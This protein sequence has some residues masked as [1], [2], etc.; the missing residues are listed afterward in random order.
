M[1]NFRVCVLLSWALFGY[2][3][4]NVTAQHRAHG[5]SNPRIIFPWLLICSKPWIPASVFHFWVQSDAEADVTLHQTQIYWKFPLWCLKFIFL[6]QK[7]FSSSLPVLY[8]S[9]MLIV[10]GI[11]SLPVLKTSCQWLCFHWYWEDEAI[12]RPTWLPQ[13]LVFNPLLFLKKCYFAVLC[14]TQDL[15][16]LTKDW[17]HGPRIGSME[18]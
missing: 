15:S 17:T 13:L 4:H 9:H 3:N 1:W 5:P 7:N 10:S 14:S 6:N 16:F 11:L 12:L 18:S 2:P 8:H